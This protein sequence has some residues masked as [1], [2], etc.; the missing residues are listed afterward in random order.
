MKFSGSVPD[1]NFPVD[2]L[3]KLLGCHSN[4]KVSYSLGMGYRLTMMS[5]KKISRPHTDRLQSSAIQ[6]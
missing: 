6:M 2:F 5:A 4:C 3:C 1:K